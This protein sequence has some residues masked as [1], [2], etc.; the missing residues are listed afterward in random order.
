MALAAD[1]LQELGNFLN[2]HGEPE[3]GA[4]ALRNAD[5]LRRRDLHGATDHLEWNRAY[6]DVYFSLVNGNAPDEA[7]ADE[8]NARYREL[9]SQAFDAARSAARGSDPAA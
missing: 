2:A 4:R 7:T 8:L 3:L 9:S 1:A 5:A 6:V